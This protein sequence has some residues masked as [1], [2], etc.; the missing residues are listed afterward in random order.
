MCNRVRAAFEFREIKVRWNL[1]NDLPEFK[2]SN[3]IGPD[4]GDILTVVRGEAGNEGR[5]MYWPLIPSAYSE[6]K[7]HPFRW[8]IDTRSDPNRH[9]FRSKSAPSLG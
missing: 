4:R 3:N 6:A 7:R 2:P 9:W 8:Q 5:L 1:F